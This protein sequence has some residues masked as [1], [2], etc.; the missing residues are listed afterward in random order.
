METEFSPAGKTSENLADST[1]CPSFP[2]K[3]G[4]NAKSLR[5]QSFP[6]QN[7]KVFRGHNAI[8]NAFVGERSSFDHN[9]T[10]LQLIRFDRVG[11]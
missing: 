2:E 8:I 1:G 5:F 3:A 6:S 11:G 9:S 7:S 4:H 10:A